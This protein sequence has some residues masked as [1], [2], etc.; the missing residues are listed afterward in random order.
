MAATKQ[1]HDVQSMHATFSACMMSVGLAT[2]LTK[3]L[4]H[5]TNNVN[6]QVQ[7]A[8]SVTTIMGEG[9]SQ[10]QKQCIPSDCKH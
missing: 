9:A 3:V 2:C 4:K 5:T 10:G 8:P 7:Q 1:E 6:S